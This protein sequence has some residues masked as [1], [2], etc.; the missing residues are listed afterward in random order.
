MLLN[1]ISS[2]FLLWLLYIRGSSDTSPIKGSLEDS[3][4]ALSSSAMDPIEF[5]FGSAKN[6]PIANEVEY[7]ELFIQATEKFY[8]NFTWYICRKLYPET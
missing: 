3:L 1:H 6:I 4:W 7:M 2:K 8:K 5:E